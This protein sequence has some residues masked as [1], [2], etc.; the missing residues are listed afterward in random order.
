MQLQNVPGKNEVTPVKTAI[1]NNVGLV[2]PPLTEEDATS[3]DFINPSVTEDASYVMASGFVKKLTTS[4]DDLRQEEKTSEDG[5]HEETPVKSKQL[6]VGGIKQEINKIGDTKKSSKG[7]KPRQILK[8]D[9]TGDDTIDE[10][11]HNVTYCRNWVRSNNPAD[12]VAAEEINWR[13]L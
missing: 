1:Q 3:V 10:K 12:A 4:L 13:K 7:F 6:Q 2:T 11:T 5:R 9:A 8:D